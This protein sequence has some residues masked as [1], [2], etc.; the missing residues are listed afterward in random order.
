MGC[1]PSDRGQLG[2]TADG[3]VGCCKETEAELT[4]FS[5]PGRRSSRSML[6]LG[7]EA[8]GMWQARGD[9]EKKRQRWKMDNAVRSAGSPA[10]AAALLSGRPA[11]IRVQQASGRAQVEARCGG[12]EG[13]GGIGSRRG[14]GLAQTTGPRQG[15]SSD[16]IR[17]VGR[18]KNRCRGRAGDW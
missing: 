15:S 11:Q 9:A 7:W 14:Q 10:G 18:G 12:D 13:G 2:R 1:A 3:G 4:R 17:R 6:A 16:A 8:D 5:N